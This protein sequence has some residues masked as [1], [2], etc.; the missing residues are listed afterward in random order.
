MQFLGFVGFNQV[1]PEYIQEWKVYKYGMA[2]LNRAWEAMDSGQKNKY[3]LDMV[4]NL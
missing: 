4:M 3:V 2:T 1:V